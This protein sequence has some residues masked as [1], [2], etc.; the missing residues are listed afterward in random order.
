MVTRQSR[1][2]RCGYIR[3]GLRWERAVVHVY[4]VALPAAV[5]ADEVHWSVTAKEVS[6]TA[7]TKGLGT[8]VWAPSVRRCSSEYGA[9]PLTVCAP[10]ANEGIKSGPAAAAPGEKK[11]H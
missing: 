2:E 8:N 6:C 1:A 3:G 10:A 4:N 11:R 7:G 5:P 9:A